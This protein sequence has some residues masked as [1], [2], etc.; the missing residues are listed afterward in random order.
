MGTR[1][2]IVEAIQQGAEAG[3]RGDDARTCPYRG[4]SL[5]RTA[6]IKGYARERPATAAAE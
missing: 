1:E 5:L 2:D 3:R 4:D 6:W